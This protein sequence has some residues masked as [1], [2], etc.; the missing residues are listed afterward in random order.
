MANR[1][2]YRRIELNTTATLG[3]DEHSQEDFVLTNI[4][5][6]GVAVAGSHPLKV[7][8]RVN[9]NLDIHPFFSYPVRKEAKIVWCR[10]VDENFWEGGLDFGMDNLINF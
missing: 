6:R 1:R 7:N 10:K 5:A 4:S 8:D 2:D 9:V 3:F